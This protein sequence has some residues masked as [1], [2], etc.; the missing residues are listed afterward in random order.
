MVK[1]TILCYMHFTINNFFFNNQGQTLGRKEDNDSSK[2]HVCNASVCQV[3]SLT[4]SGWK[5]KRV[6]VISHFK[7]RRAREVSPG[8][9]QHCKWRAESGTQ[10]LTP[11]QA[12]SSHSEEPPR[13]RSYRRARF[14][15]AKAAV[16]E[17]RDGAG[18]E[19]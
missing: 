17:P 14:Q 8:K 15:G 11:F 5:R 18:E 3:L 16:G 7:G 6:G 1:L 13:P 4:T 19:G 12:F 10:L 9:S 2:S